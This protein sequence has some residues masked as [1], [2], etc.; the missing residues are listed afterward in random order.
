MEITYKLIGLNKPWKAAGFNNVFATVEIGIEDWGHYGFN[1]KLFPAD[2][3]NALFNKFK[4]SE[5]NLW[6]KKNHKVV[7]DYSGVTPNTPTI[8]EL[9]LDGIA[10]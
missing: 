6:H 4:N 2:R 10:E 1:E 7:L 5:E 8:K 9:I 3:L